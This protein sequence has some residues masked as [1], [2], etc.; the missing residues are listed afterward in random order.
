MVGFQ[1]HSLV[2][3][4]RGAGR[5]GSISWRLHDDVARRMRG[6]ARSGT[7]SMQRLEY[8]N[9]YSHRVT[10]GSSVGSGLRIDKGIYTRY[11]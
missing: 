2:F 10:H 3:Q 4:L 5:K 1:P 6:E 7:I 11:L 9:R 8:E